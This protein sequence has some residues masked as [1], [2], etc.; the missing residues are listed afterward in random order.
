MWIDS[1]FLRKLVKSPVVDVSASCLPHPSD[2]IQVL[3]MNLWWWFLRDLMDSNAMKFVDHLIE[4]A[5]CYGKAKQSRTVQSTAITWWYWLG[6]VWIPLTVAD[7]S[8]IYV[9][10]GIVDHFYIHIRINIIFVKMFSTASGVIDCGIVFSK[11]GYNLLVPV[12][13]NCPSGWLLAFTRRQPED[14]L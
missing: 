13:T 3:K 7:F 10:P 8:V 4:I 1:P 2:L 9:S 11:V 14:N 12:C 5:C 6:S